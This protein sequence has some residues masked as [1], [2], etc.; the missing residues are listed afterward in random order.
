MEKPRIILDTN[1]LVA[2]FRSTQGASFLLLELLSSETFSIHFSLPL[3][4]EY[5][6]VLQREALLSA[7]ELDKF[8]KRLHSIGTM[9]KI[10][11]LFRWFLSDHDD[12]MVLEIAIA[13]NATHIITFNKKD[14]KPA[15]MFGIQVLTP[16]EFLQY[17]GVL[18]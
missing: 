8:L 15:E 3:L 17:L 14:L 1:V 12:D 4:L 18:P 2:A 9:H 5:E 11:F 7:T 10:Y 16:K 13:S 6:E